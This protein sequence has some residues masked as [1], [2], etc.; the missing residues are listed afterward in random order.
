[1]PATGT[2]H[3]ELWLS[4]LDLINAKRHSLI[5]YIYRR[6]PGGDFNVVQ[7]LKDGLS[8]VLMHFYPSAGRLIT[9]AT[10]R[11]A[12]DCNGESALFVEAVTQMEID[13]LG[14]FSSPSELSPLVPPAAYH[15]GITTSP[16]LMIQIMECDLKFDVKQRL[17]I[18]SRSDKLSVSRF[19]CGGIVVGV[20]LRH[21]LVDGIAALHFINTC[22]IS[23]SR[24]IVSSPI[25]Q[26]NQMIYD[27]ILKMDDEY[28]H[29]QLDYLELEHDL[30]SFSMYD[31]NDD[32]I[33]NPN[34]IVNG[35]TSWPFVM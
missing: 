26:T 28:L 24:D 29:S 13:D 17:T 7:L 11:L 31:G 4:N 35:W 8:K 3:H 33:N 25:W 19:K 34:L 16:L 30:S 27:E 1:R 6:P 10:G 22:I 15:D 23:V 21:N 20:G 18:K 2:P 12:V 14:E 9:D 32:G 5:V